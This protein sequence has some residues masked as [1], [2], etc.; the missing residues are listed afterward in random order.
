M[1]IELAKTGQSRMDYAD[2]LTGQITQDLGQ[3]LDK[4]KVLMEKWS[5]TLEEIFN[6]RQM[7]IMELLKVKTHTNYGLVLMGFL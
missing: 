2:K 7:R 3:Q 5:L 1:I 4:Y 6:E